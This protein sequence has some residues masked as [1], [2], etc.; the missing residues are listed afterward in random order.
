MSKCRSRSKHHFRCTW[1]PHCKNWHNHCHLKPPSNSLASRHCTMSCCPGA[2]RRNCTRRLTRRTASPR[3]HTARTWS[4]SSRSLVQTHPP[5][6]CHT[7]WPASRQMQ[8]YRTCSRS[9]SGYS[10]ESSQSGWSKTPA[11][12]CHCNA[13]CTRIGTLPKHG[14]LGICRIRKR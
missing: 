2:W 5:S 6:N 9:A 4:P 14:G 11:C 3:W 12:L 7:C 10:T 8:C 1:L 13:Q